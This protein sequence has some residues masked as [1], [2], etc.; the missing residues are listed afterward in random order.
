ME[1]NVRTAVRENLQYSQDYPTVGNEGSL[2]SSPNNSLPGLKLH[3][4]PPQWSGTMHLTSL[5]SVW[6]SQNPTSVTVSDYPSVCS[7][8][9]VHCFIQTVFTVYSESNVFFLSFW[10]VLSSLHT[11]RRGGAGSEVYLCLLRKMRL[12]EGHRNTLFLATSNMTCI[13]EDRPLNWYRETAHLRYVVELA[14]E[15][16]DLL[17]LYVSELMLLS[18]SCNVS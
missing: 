14:L 17:R 4:F 1:A 18:V 7:A 2:P 15:A 8:A 11:S 6:P 9:R 12:R 5:L 13:V 3:S 10:W 16:K